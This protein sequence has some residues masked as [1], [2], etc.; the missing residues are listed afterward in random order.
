[1]MKFLDAARL[2]RGCWELYRKYYG[3]SM[4]KELWEQFIAETEVLYQKCGKTD[5]AKE[6]I[7]AVINEI[8]RIDKGK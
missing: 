6:L 2:F 8:E 7:L 4:N 1:M 3:Q 5:M